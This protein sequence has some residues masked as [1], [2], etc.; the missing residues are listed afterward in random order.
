MSATEQAILRWAAREVFPDCTDD[1]VP[2]AAELHDWIATAPTYALAT[3]GKALDVITESSAWTWGSYPVEQDAIAGSRLDGS[4]LEGPSIVAQGTVPSA[5]LDLTHVHAAWKDY[6]KSCEPDETPPEH[7]AVTL[8]RAWLEQPAQVK[9]ETR[10]DKRILPRIAV[11]ANPAREAGMLFAGLHQGR[12]LEVSELPLFPEVAPA[13]RVPLLDLVDAA[14]LPVMARGRGAPLP[15]R[16]FVRVLAAVRPAHRR[17][18]TTRL[19]LTLRE[20]SGG[21]FPNGW[22][23][24]RD[25]PKLRH[26]LMHTRD[27]AIHDGRG[28]WFPLALRLMPDNPGLDDIIVL[29]VAYPPDSHSGPSVSL[30]EMDRLSVDSA[31]RWR[32]YIAVHCIAWQPG[33]TRVPAPRAGGRFVWARKAT[34]YPILTCHDRR[35]LA[36]GAGDRKHRTR[37]QVDE[38]FRGLPGLVVVSECAADERTGE[39]GWLV[40]PEEAAGALTGENEGANRGVSQT[41]LIDS[42]SLGLL[43]NPN[44]KVVGEAHGVRSPWARTPRRER[45]ELLQLNAMPANISGGGRRCTPGCQL[46]WAQTSVEKGGPAREGQGWPQSPSWHGPVPGASFR[47]RSHP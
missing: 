37:A 36:F 47:F 20:L 45:Q 17:L 9:P 12:C 21:L 2:T 3:A 40:L 22:E 8:V 23:R 42:Q 44:T 31:A 27:Y 5:V 18:P 4:T 24:R 14:G 16:L 11:S 10:R 29:D 41:Q 6:A 43:P 19:E 38:V 28:R 34:A 1:A 32:A 33:K 15:L 7:P 13:K 46:G 35:R 25:W 30:P 26:A 39:V